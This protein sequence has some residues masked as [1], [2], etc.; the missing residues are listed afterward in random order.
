MPGS[1]K[2]LWALYI[3]FSHLITPAASPVIP[4]SFKETH[5]LSMHVSVFAYTQ[6][7]MPCTHLL[8]PFR[9]QTETL[10]A[11][12]VIWSPRWEA[13]LSFSSPLPLP[14]FSLPCPAPATPPRTSHPATPPCTRQSHPCA[15]APYS[16]AAPS[17]PDPSKAE[18][19]PN[20]S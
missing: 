2:R 5:P 10:R 13:T 18:Q 3:G 20:P 19:N 6:P 1:F 9:W 12:A 16:L 7:P 15:R 8:Y 4:S 17:M 11:V 14:C